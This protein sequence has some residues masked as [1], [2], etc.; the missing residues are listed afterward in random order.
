MIRATGGPTDFDDAV[1][2]LARQKSEGQTDHP[3]GVAE[4]AVDR[5]MRLAGV[6]RSQNRDETGRKSPWPVIHEARCGLPR[7]SSQAAPAR[8]L[9]PACPAELTTDW[10]ACEQGRNK[11]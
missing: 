8:H 11:P 3:R 5:Q 6:G 7:A 10:L 9:G 2:D 4:H 1:V